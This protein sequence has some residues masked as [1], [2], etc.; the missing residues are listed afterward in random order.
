MERAKGIEP[1][2]VTLATWRST[3]ELCPLEVGQCSECTT[4]RE[5]VKCEI[6]KSAKKALVREKRQKNGAGKGDRTLD[7]HVG[8]VALYR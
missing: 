1:S 6:E 2:T 4:E 7:S 8:N 5:K 3:A